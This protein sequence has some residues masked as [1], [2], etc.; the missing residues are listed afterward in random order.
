MASL[1]SA[2]LSIRFENLLRCNF[3]IYMSGTII[4]S[5]GTRNHQGEVLFSSHFL[6]HVS[7]G[8]F[9][10]GLEMTLRKLR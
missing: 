6:S 1:Q 7:F 9:V 2:D 8:F 5:M 4:N 3:V 10:N